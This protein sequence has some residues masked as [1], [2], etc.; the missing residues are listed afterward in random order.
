MK[1][2]QDDS[3]FSRDICREECYLTEYYDGKEGL[4]MLI[5]SYEE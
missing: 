3:G 4:K 2:R 5:E 1:H